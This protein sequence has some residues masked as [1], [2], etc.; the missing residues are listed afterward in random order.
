MF[1]QE[2]GDKGGWVTAQEQAALAPP[3][4]LL[5]RLPR[6]HTLTFSRSSHPPGLRI[7][8]RALW[9]GGTARDRTRDA[10]TSP[11]APPTPRGKP[12]YSSAAPPSPTVPPPPALVLVRTDRWLPLPFRA[13]ASEPHADSICS[14]GGRQR[15]QRGRLEGGSAG[16]WGTTVQPAAGHTTPTGCRHSLCVSAQAAS[17]RVLDRYG[18]W[19]GGQ[20]PYSFRPRLSPSLFP[21]ARPTAALLDGEPSGRPCLFHGPLPPTAAD[22]ADNKRAGGPNSGCRCHRRRCRCCRWSCGDGGGSVG[23][24]GVGASRSGGVAAA[25]RHSWAVDRLAGTDGARRGVEIH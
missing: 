7:R 11:N 5:Q 8:G 17:Q 10:L 4:P 18:R 24:V 1:Q 6:Q 21:H 14:R 13:A 20:P 22:A 2:S 25:R 16:S 19:E 15:R 12:A 3:G 9:A 23:G